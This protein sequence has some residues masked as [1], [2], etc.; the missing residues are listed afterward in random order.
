METGKF[1]PLRENMGE[2]VKI[3]T[4]D[5]AEPTFGSAGLKTQ[6]PGGVVTVSNF[7][8]M[9]GGIKPG[10]LIETDLG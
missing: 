8:T 1:A 9:A 7:S 4:G 5:Y 2:V 6:V 3:Y 10:N